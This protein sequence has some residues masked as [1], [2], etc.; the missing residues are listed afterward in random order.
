[1][2]I[3]SPSFF[4]PFLDDGSIGCHNFNVPSVGIN[5]GTTLIKRENWHNYKNELVIRK[6]TSYKV[7]TDT[8]KGAR[9]RKVLLSAYGT[10][11][12]DSVNT[13]SQSFI[14][15]SYSME[16]SELGTA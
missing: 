13:S 2:Y 15:H 3:L 11:S 4:V 7:I 9:K 14:G 5:T 8:G 1:L 16:K 10:Q 12:T 6:D